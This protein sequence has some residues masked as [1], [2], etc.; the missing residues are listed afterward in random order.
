MHIKRYLARVTIILIFILKNSLVQLLAAQHWS[1]IT[2]VVTTTTT[3]TTTIPSTTI[4]PASRNHNKNKN[5][6]NLRVT[7]L[8]ALD[9]D[10]WTT[11]IA[12][13]G[14]VVATLCGWMI[15]PFLQYFHHTGYR[16]MEHDTSTVPTHYPE[17]HGLTALLQCA[18]VI[19][20]LATI[21]SD[22]AYR[23]AH[24]VRLIYYHDVPMI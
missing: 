2:G 19:L 4:S 15:A 3:T 12:G 21:C 11:M 14:S 7:S 6:S 10:R 9:S 17:Y 1:F 16:R 24:K 18:A 5:N 22:E 23:V 8:P 13:V 20:I